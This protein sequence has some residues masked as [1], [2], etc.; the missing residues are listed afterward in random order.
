MTEAILDA[1]PALATQARRTS[2]RKIPWNLWVFGTL[3]ALLILLGIF[4]PLLAGNVTSGDLQHRLLGIGQG[5]H[6][7]GTDGQGRD[8]LAR[9]I[10]GARPSMISGIVPVVVA[11]IVGGAI[12]VAA[13][14][15]GR[16]THSAIM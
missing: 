9:L 3:A 15:S 16:R 6:L 11:G 5:G 1:A 8:V 7:L 10:A 4:G 14:L 2:R 12:G 13:G